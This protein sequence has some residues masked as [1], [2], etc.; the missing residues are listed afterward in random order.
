[1]I[2]STPHT[3]AL[4]SC[5]YLSDGYLTCLNRQNQNNDGT[6]SIN[7]GQ[8]LPAHDYFK[9][10][11]GYLPHVKLLRAKV[12]EQLVKKVEL[13]DNPNREILLLVVLVYQTLISQQY[14]TYIHLV[15]QKDPGIKCSCRLFLVDLQVAKCLQTCH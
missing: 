12:N 15:Y 6:Y 9:L 1:M 3:A 8:P 5:F 14:C 11:V 4:H 7:H 10:T 2:Q 13:V